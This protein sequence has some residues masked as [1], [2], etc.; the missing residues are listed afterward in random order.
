M[1]VSPIRHPESRRIFPPVGKA[2]LIS[3]VIHVV[4]LVGIDVSTRLGLMDRAKLPDWLRKALPS[5]PRLALESKAR[6]PEPKRQEEQL[7]YIDVLPSQA[8][9]DSPD[10]AKYYSAANSRAANPDTSKNLKTPKIDG[11]QKQVAKTVDIAKPAPQP[12]EAEPAK[13]EKTPEQQPAPQP[14]QPAQQSP[15]QA[16]TAQPASAPAGGEQAGNERTAKPSLFPGDPS[17]AAP[18]RKP[19]E[20]VAEAKPL[21]KPRT[22][23]EAKARK[24]GGLAGEKMQQEGGSKKFALQPSFDARATPFGAYDAAV[25]M[26]IQKCWY[27]SLDETEAARGQTGRVV[28][29]FRLHSNGSVTNFKLVERTV[30]EVMALICQRAI[31]APAP[32]AP[33]PSDMRRLVGADYRDVTFTFYSN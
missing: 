3:L 8:T 25:I 33:W 15:A 12:A 26:A 14:L 22:I 32:Y 28:V 11:K 2:L 5:E 10:E 19:T 27:D 20:E 23:A 29:S 6:L 13:P 7:M 21:P 4:A 30:G 9:P 1:D 16:Q 17:L 24:S 18:E 31:T